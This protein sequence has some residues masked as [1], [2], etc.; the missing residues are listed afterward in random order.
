MMHRG[1]PHFFPDQGPG[2]LPG[3]TGGEEGWIS[4]FYITEQENLS[5]ESPD[6]EEIF[7]HFLILL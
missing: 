2:R 6:V 5:P 4:A 3:S 1:Y 7:A